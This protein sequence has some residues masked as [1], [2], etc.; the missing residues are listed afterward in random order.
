MQKGTPEY[1]RYWRG[2]VFF[3]KGVQNVSWRMPIGEVCKHNAV[4]V[5]CGDFLCMSLTRCTC[6]AH[7]ITA[8]THVS[9]LMNSDILLTQSFV[10]AISVVNEEFADWFL[11][12]ARYVVTILCS[13]VCMRS[14]HCWVWCLHQVCIHAM[15]Y[16]ILA[17]AVN[18][19]SGSHYVVRRIR[20]G[21]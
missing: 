14:P 1:A 12:G 18:V 5:Y 7:G 9:V 16:W 4:L 20:L 15:W 13:L 3:S 10:D 17:S 11:T 2:R 21:S 8:N 6:C 19:N